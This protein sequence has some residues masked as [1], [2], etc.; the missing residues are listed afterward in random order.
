MG[1]R[2]GVCVKRL[3]LVFAAVL[4]LAAV[5]PYLLPL[6]NSREPLPAQPFPNSAGIEVGGVRLHVRTWLPDAEIGDGACAFLLIHGFAGSTFSWRELAPRLAARGHVVLAVDLPS[7]GYSERRNWALEDGEA[8]WRLLEATRPGARWCLIGHSMGARVAAAVASRHPE[9]IDAVVY[10]GGWPLSRVRPGLRQR[11]AVRLLRLPSV[12]RWASVVA[13]RSQFNEAR[14]AHLLESAYGRPPTA[15]EVAGYL[16]PMRV[17]GT[18]PAVLERMTQAR[19]EVDEA[20]I[21]RL[22]TLLLWGAEDA[23]VPVAVAERTR[24][25]F[26]AFALLRLPGSG[27][28]PMETHPEETWAALLGWLEARPPREGEG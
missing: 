9:R 28:V 23:W 8:L 4:L 18:V 21:A 5:A 10:L 16:A 6:Q 13:D 1:H 15:D 20:A 22:P 7:F 24:E 11:L 12:Q 25:R 26:P 17:R 19:S 2:T 14:F 27:H 3:T